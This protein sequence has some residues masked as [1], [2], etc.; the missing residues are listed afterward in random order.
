MIDVAR[1]V[2]IWYVPPAAEVGIDLSL[3]NGEAKF[4]L[5][6]RSNEEVKLVYV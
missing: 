5:S 2:R 3:E 4:G 6:M 1:A